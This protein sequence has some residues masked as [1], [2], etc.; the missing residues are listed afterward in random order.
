LFAE[1]RLR[2]RVLLLTVC[3]GL[4][5]A[6]A[7][8]AA[9]AKSATK[10]PAK[11]APKSDAKTD[12]VVSP[13]ED[14]SP[15]AATVNGTAIHTA[16][17][18]AALLPTT[19]GRHLPPDALELLQAEALAQL[20]DRVLIEAFL[21]GDAKPVTP[22]EVADALAKFKTQLEGQKSTLDQFLAEKHL[23]LETLR[24]QIAWQILW[25]R[26]RQKYLTS[27]ALES[28]FDA[29]RKEF[30]G[31]EVRASHILLRPA[32]AGDAQA[33]PRL[34]KEATALREQIEAGKISFAD[35][36]AK[37]SAGPS[38]EK[39]GDIGFFPRNG[40]MVEPF[41]R[42]AF[43][44]EKGQISPPV[45]TNFGVHL[46][47]I[48]DVTPGKKKWTDVAEQLKPP[49]AQAMFEKLAE[50]ERAKA[51]IEFTA[52]WPHFKPGTHELEKAQ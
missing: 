16:E 19:E 28:Y 3:F 4:S 22:E 38:R 21:S 2:T 29:H 17:I 42:A 40:L 6:E 45:I 25:D 11:G 43:A 14:T 51:Q 52:A 32:T 33:V 10:A 24:R 18:E 7:V 15:V 30:D 27:A 31:S 41:A 9:P 44:L 34:V 39:A 26:G 46:I 23:T 20:I 37:Y 49:A 12:Q 36:A 1:C 5:W 13:P 35:A 47:Q 8:I 48:T 50:R